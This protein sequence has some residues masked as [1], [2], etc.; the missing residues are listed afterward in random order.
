MS[1]EKP[2]ADLRKL[3]VVKKVM[4]PNTLY[5]PCEVKE[6]FK[7]TIKAGKRLTIE[8]EALERINRTVND[9]S[10]DPERFIDSLVT[11]QKALMG[12]NVSLIDYV[13]AIRFC[14]F[15][16]VHEGNAVK[17]YI[18]TFKDRD[19]V[20]DKL[21]CHRSSREWKILY[22]AATRYRKLPLVVNILTQ[23]EVP[24]YLMFQ[25]YRYRAVSVLVEEMENAKYS[26]DKINA[27]DKLLTHLK[28]PENVK[29]ELDVGI[30]RDN[31]VN[32]YEEMLKGMVEKQRELLKAGE[33]VE[34]IANSKANY[35]D[36]VVISENR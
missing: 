14:G 6:W 33:E 13:N 16:E 22:G 32:Q 9:E 31:I 30:S 17:A 10:F 3:G 1:N 8:G 27:A 11:Y 29:I 21:D 26:R 24:L 7:S 23:A 19:F 15:M 5:E 28:P 18:D 34:S 20:K 2:N 25:G 4:K 35:L 12:E 36:A